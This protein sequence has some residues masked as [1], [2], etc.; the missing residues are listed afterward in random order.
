ML[1][2]ILGG[3]LV[4]GLCI[5]IHELGHYLA[6]RLVGVKAEIFSVGYGRAIWK[7]KIGDTTWQITAIPFGGYVLFYGADFTQRDEV[8]PGGLFSVGPLRRMIPILGG[9]VFNLILGFLVFLGLHLSSGPIAPRIDFDNTIQER[10]PA[11]QAGLR[12]GDLVLSINGAPVRSFH[13]IWQNTA[14][15]EGRPLDFLVDRNGQQQT[16]TVRPEVSES[17]VAEVGV[18]MPGELSLGVNYPNFAVWKYRFQR[19]FGEPTL[20]RELRALPFLHDGD[21]ILAINGEPV[22]SVRDLQ[23]SLGK[24]HGETVTV[25]VRRE[26]LPWL[27]PWF[28]H[29]TETRVPSSP[30]YIVHLRD[31]VDQKYGAEIYDQSFYSI[32]QEHQRGL[33]SVRL[34][35]AP[36]QSF[37]E[38][39]RRYPA[40]TEVDL[41]LGAHAYRAR[42]EVEKTG[43]LGFSPAPMI[44][45]DYL[46]RHE[47][48]ANVLVFAA[49]DTWSNVM[50]YPAFFKSLF[51][52]RV[53]LVD[54]AAGP[55]R[56]FGAA[57]MITR[58]DYQ[59]YL[60][61]FGA[62]SIA[63]FV[64]NLLPFPMLDGGHLVMYLYEAAAGRPAPVQVQEAIFKFG[65]TVILGFALWIMYRDL[66]WAIG[67]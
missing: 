67:L 27:A 23:L 59:N 3:A 1:V 54:N 13:D 58:T 26:S 2:F 29:E 64:M 10:S 21:V 53:S 50:L 12:D 41:Q 33:A 34:D 42:V 63:L 40:P 66:L 18:R 52:G 65:F 45:G 32:A 62:I 11:Y 60:T 56:I 14:L 20:P 7:K 44:K 31:I 5:F 49:R 30:E 37:E 24:H 48:L 15:S 51:A 25:R 36:A 19:L 35:G 55:I 8:T 46:A 47:S 17:G 61:L 43:L 6:G 16:I 22:R 38:L 28:T 4:L 57:G 39:A 9:P